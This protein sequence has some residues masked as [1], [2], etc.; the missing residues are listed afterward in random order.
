MTD[1]DDEDGDP[2]ESA[3]SAIEVRQEALRLWP[4]R[5]VVNPAGV[6]ILRQEIAVLKAQVARLSAQ[7]GP[8]P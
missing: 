8:G 4:R 7:R 5:R 2:V 1:D 6:Q 3:P